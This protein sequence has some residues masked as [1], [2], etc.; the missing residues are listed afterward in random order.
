MISLKT[1]NEKTQD[2]YKTKCEN[3]HMEIIN[4]G[5]SPLRYGK[6]ILLAL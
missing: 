2:W 3:Y 5:N 6:A 1:L 4:I